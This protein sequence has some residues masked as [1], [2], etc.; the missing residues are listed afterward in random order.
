MDYIYRHPTPLG[1]MLMASDGASLTGLWIEGQR[2]CAETLLPE[3]RS[4][5]R[6][7][8][9]FLTRLWLDLYLDHHRPDFVPP[10]ALRGTDFQRRVW[11]AL[12][13]IPFGTTVTY[14]DVARAIG[15]PSARAVGNA[16]AHNPLLLIVPCHRVLAKDGSVSGFSAGKDVKKWLLYLE[17]DILANRH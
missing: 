1:T 6:L 16:I 5:E 9:F 3:H 14:S 7:P 11:R 2:Y 12:L 4:R 17:Q 8:V 10:L 13:D 15:S